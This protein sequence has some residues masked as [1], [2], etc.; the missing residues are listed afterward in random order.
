MQIISLDWD[1]NNTDHIAR[2]EVSPEEAEEVCFSRSYYIETGR[3]KYYYITGQTESGRYLFLVIKYL[4]RRKAR[5][6][7]ARDMDK[8][9]KS[10][11]KKKR[12]K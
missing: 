11:Y 5:V 8:K 10:R 7:T 4:G 3:D 1:E 6:V 12:R 2:H 9:E